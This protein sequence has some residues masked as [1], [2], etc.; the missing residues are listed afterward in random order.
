MLKSFVVEVDDGGEND[1]SVITL[2]K[3]GRLLLLSL[4]NEG[5]MEWT[6]TRSLTIASRKT[7]GN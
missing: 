5:D 3:E 4:L 2:V 1:S 7:L 6:W